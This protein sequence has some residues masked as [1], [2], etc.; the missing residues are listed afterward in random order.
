MNRLD[1]AFTVLRIAGAVLGIVSYIL[2]VNKARALGVSTNLVQQALL[3]P[4]SIRNKVWDGVAVGSFFSA[5][6]VHAL[7]AE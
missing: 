4:W 7:V 6:N 3:T 2:L 5:V 1:R